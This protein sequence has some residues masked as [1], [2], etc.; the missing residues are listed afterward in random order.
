MNLWIILTVA[1]VSAAV[2]ACMGCWLIP[3]LKRLKYGQTILEEGPKWH[4]KK[5]GTPT[6]G[7]LM[8]YMGITAAF[9]AGY[10]IL[11]LNGLISFETVGFSDT[12]RGISGLIMALCFGF[13]GFIDDY[14][15]I[16][17]KRN[18]GLTVIQKIVL[19][20]LI[21]AAYFTSRVIGGD[22][23]TVLN[24]P[25]I[26]QLDLSFFY[27]IFMGLVILYLVNAVN[28]TDG[29]D[30]LCSS[31]SFVYFIVFAVITAQIQLYGM[32]VL[33]VASAGGVLGFLMWNFPPAKVFM[34]DTGSLFLG[35][36]VCALGIGSGC[37]VIMIVAAA[38]FIWEALTVLIQ[39]TYFKITHGKRLFKM[40]PIHHS[41][42]MRGWSE[43]KI[44]AVFSMLAMLAGAAAILL[45]A[46]LLS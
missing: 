1:V 44:D 23:S 37:E 29:I 30:G 41:F 5:Q 8:F 7:G 16:R 34:G 33:S 17:K 39:T 20:V 36:L 32:T 46:G 28:L 21:I 43:V 12:M 31:V 18:Q 26:G 9:I 40:T 13:V 42:E 14:I 25:F 6:M 38:V 15:K 11:Y 2:T 4:E 19:Q 27:Y 10:V 24:I 22:T 35:G 45:S 3:L